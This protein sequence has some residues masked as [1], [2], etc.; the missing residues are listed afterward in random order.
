[1]QSFLRE[2]SPPPLSLAQGIVYWKPPPEALA[3]A[4]VCRVQQHETLNIISL[5]FHD[6]AHAT[7]P[8]ND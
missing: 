7:A 8:L 5:E 3:A 6:L 4:Q 1:M 2:I